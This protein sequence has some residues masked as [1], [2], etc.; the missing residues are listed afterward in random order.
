MR[1]LCMPERRC[2][3]GFAAAVLSSRITAEGP[4]SCL[5][6]K[7]SIQDAIFRESA[8]ESVPA[9]GQLAAWLLLG[10]CQSPGT[11][12]AS[13]R[14]P[15]YWPPETCQLGAWHLLRQPAS[16]SACEHSPDAEWR[17]AIETHQRLDSASCD[18]AVR[19]DCR[20]CRCPCSHTG[21]CSSFHAQTCMVFGK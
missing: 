11:S 4:F 5:S 21:T 8:I 6:R 18:R 2:S 17:F 13:V 20:R 14:L 16:S 3:T 10:R 15:S 7:A 9:P 1:I 12:D 19:K